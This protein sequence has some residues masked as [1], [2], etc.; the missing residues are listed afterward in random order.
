MTVMCKK[1]NIL[2]LQI[3]KI[4]L[5]KTTQVDQQWQHKHCRLQASA[6]LP[7]LIILEILNVVIN[8]SGI[9]SPSALY[10]MPASYFKGFFNN[11]FFKY[12]N[13]YK[14]ASLNQS[15]NYQRNINGHVCPEKKESLPL[16]IVA[17]YIPT[18][19]LSI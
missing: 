13:F 9:W 14:L 18:S 6:S 11:L 5:Q 3:K 12:S 4:A 7:V 1:W 15:T 10:Y 8:I 2:L 16:L 19:F 17:L